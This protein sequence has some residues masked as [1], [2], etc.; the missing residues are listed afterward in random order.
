MRLGFLNHEVTQIHSAA[1]LLGAAGFL[2][3]LLG[4]AR[5]RA[6][7]STF[8]AGRELDIYY[9]AFQIPDFMSVV[10][11]LGAASAAILPIF[12]EYLAKDAKEA[13]QLIAGILILFA[14]GAIV[15]SA[16][17]ALFTP[18]FM[19]VITPGFTDEDR[20]TAIILTRIMLLSPILLGFSG[21]FSSVVQSFQRFWAYALAPIL[22]NLG[23]ITGIFAFVP[24]FGVTGLALG[25][26][27]GSLLHLSI[28]LIT[29]VQLGFSPFSVILPTLKPSLIMNDGVKRILAISLPR[30]ISVS[31][32]SITLLA[33][34]A[35]GSTLSEGSIAVFQLA[36]N[37]YFMPIGIFGVSYAIAIFPRLSKAFIVKDKKDF[38][39]ELFLGIRTI[40]FWTAP[41][42]VLFVVLRAH[43]VRVALGAGEFSWE[44]TRLTAA[45]LAILASAMFAGGLSTLLIKGFYALENTWKPLYI[46]ITASIF[47][48]GT[49]FY[50]AREL[51]TPSWLNQLIGPVLRIEDLTDMGVLGLAIGFSS[52]LVINILFLY[53]ML[54][55]QARRTFNA[56]ERF[57]LNVAARILFSAILGGGAAYL[58][59]ASFSESLPLIT[60][61]QV[62]WQGFISGIIG[63]VVYFASLYILGSAEIRSFLAT[64]KKKVFR[65][66]ALPQ[67]WDGE[68]QLH[69][70][71]SI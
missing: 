69:Q 56:S 45:V 63:F 13:K 5:D 19:N 20:T 48:V 23:I 53:I 70:H 25:V 24:F 12:Q 49:A 60:F 61:M 32:T 58:A 52:G 4:V 40:L 18:Y 42:A 9:A 7:A 38:F 28:Q 35:I 1:L 50:L 51:S 44:D 6:L 54:I 14:L 3:R 27:L 43:I 34:I 16:I 26:L 33:L 41:S 39:E 29:V 66:S 68:S 21:I 65:V 62:L 37:L 22:Y 10:F 31:F 17:G 47:S 2:S 36:Q 71:R 11:L 8:G 46:N 64:L 55:R 59:R 67:H 30:V 57:P 15:L